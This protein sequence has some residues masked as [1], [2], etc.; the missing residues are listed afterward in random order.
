MFNI[1]VTGSI[2]DHMRKHCVCGGGGQLVNQRFFFFKFAE[3]LNLPA[4]SK[5][6]KALKCVFN[7]CDCISIAAATLPSVT[8]LLFGVINDNLY[9]QIVRSNW[10]Y[11]VERKDK[12]SLQEKGTTKKLYNNFRK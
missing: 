6:K 3:E 9:D 11:L 7:C 12:A 4:S 5:L 10:L 2:R 8:L 1:L